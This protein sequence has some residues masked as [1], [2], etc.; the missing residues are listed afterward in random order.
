MYAEEINRYLDLHFG[1]SVP[2]IYLEPGRGLV[3]EAGVLVSEVVSIAK[4][5]KTDLKRWVYT[6]VGIFNGLMELSLIH[7]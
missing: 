3:G 1:D 6:D 5:S 7:I 2:A 4:K